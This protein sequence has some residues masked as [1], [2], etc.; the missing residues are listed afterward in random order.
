MTSKWMTI[1][2]GSLGK[3]L[4]ISEN[5]SEKG[6]KK[7]IVPM[8]R[9]CRPQG[10]LDQ[11]MALSQWYVGWR[12][13]QSLKPRPPP[14][15]VLH[16]CCFPPWKHHS[17]LPSLNSWWGVKHP[18]THHIRYLLKWNL[19]DQFQ[20][21]PN[22]TYILQAEHQSSLHPW[23]CLKCG[24][25]LWARKAGKMASWGW[26][27]AWLATATVLIRALILLPLIRGPASFS[28]VKHCPHLSSPL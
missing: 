22:V 5:G 26:V 9:C 2:W 12:V 28:C 1:P 24:V 17:R 13:G 16:I 6:Y 20:L 27:G 7:Y 23:Y 15:P 21:I 14:A 25:G 18:S 4:Q 3:N 11:R 19:L 10:C 8:P